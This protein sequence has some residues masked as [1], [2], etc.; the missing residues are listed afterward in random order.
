ML[1]VGG[2]LTGLT[3]AYTL[4]K[5]GINVKLVEASPRFGG[6]IQSDYHQGYLLESGPNTFISTAKEL[7]ALVHELGITPLATEPTANKRF[8]WHQGQLKPL[9]TNLLAF[10]RS[11]LLSVSGKLRLLSEPLQR[12]RSSSS[13]ETLA[14]FIKRRLGTEVLETMVSPFVSGIYAGDPYQL[15]ARA[16]FRKLV[17]WEQESGSIFMGAIKA[18][19]EKK[20]A[21]KKEKYKL[22]S[23]EDGL[24]TLVDTLVSQLP[25]E[26]IHTH[27]KASS[28]TQLS[29]G[30]YRLNS[31]DGD[32]VDAPRVILATP[33]YVSAELVKSMAPTLSTP[34]ASIPYAPMAVVHVGVPRSAISAAHLAKIDEGFGCLIPRH[35]AGEPLHIPTLGIIFSS[36]LLRRR[37]PKEHVLLTCFIGGA[38]Q[39]E[40]ANWS[41]VECFEIV[42]NDLSTLFGIL[43]N[44]ISMHRITHWKQAIPQYTSDDVGGHAS[45]VSQITEGLRAFP[46]LVLAGNYLEGVSLNDCVKQGQQAASH[47]TLE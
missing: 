12:N 14:S 10:L 47:A 24:Q 38:T 25:E 34:L 13:D 42:Q 35:G 44:D 27:W 5:Q 23:F 2:G 19:R 43:P 30:E 6:V 1:V 40:S 31:V 22:L 16:V 33:A 26:V 4:H 37:A 20:S 15:S 11:D 28:L 41:D 3:A 9:P 21:S 29:S 32:F 46:G 36:S 7:M 8:I 39:P 17:D 45:R 18:R